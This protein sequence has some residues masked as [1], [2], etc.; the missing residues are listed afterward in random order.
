MHFR[1]RCGGQAVDKTVLDVF[2]YSQNL[3][4]QGAPDRALVLIIVIAG[5]DQPFIQGEI[6]IGECDFLRR[7]SEFPST[8]VTLF[9]CQETCLAQPPQNTPHNDRISACMSGDIG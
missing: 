5:S 9:G 3:A 7:A 6:N 1:D 4:V 2:Q 8:G